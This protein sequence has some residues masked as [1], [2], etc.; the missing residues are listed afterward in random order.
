MFQRTELLI[1][2][3]KLEILKN[4]HVI[5]FG[6]GGVGGYVVEGLVRA[7]VG[8]LT[9][10]DFDVVDISNL[11]RQIIAT[12]SNVGKP[13][14]QLIEERAKSINPDIKINSFEEMFSEENSELFFNDNVKYDYIIDAIDLITH[15]IKIIEMAEKYKTKIISSMGTANKME[16]LKLR[17][18]KIEKTIACPLAK[19]IRKE[20]R[21]RRIGKNL[22]VLYSLEEVKKV[23]N[24][25]GRGNFRKLGSISFVPATAGLIIASEVIK[26]LIDKSKDR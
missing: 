4:S 1:G 11:N 8:T 18:D 25:E 13:K 14:V 19:I 20:L 6:M 7:G 26:E 15:K 3:E 2:K 10:I 21:K 24:Q 16:P 5:I 23:E 22:K 12:Q 9:I 17:I